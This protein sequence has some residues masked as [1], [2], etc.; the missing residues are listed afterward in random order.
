MWM[1]RYCLKEGDRECG[2]V[3]RSIGVVKNEWLGV[4]FKLKVGFVYK[5]GSHFSVVV[6][7]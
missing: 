3:L 1:N 7:C 2:E 4:K 5:Q 6:Y